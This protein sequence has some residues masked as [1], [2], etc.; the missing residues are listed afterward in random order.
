MGSYLL[1][2]VD[3]MPLSLKPKIKSYLLNIIL[4]KI[5]ILISYHICFVSFL[6]KRY[7]SFPPCCINLLIVINDPDVKIVRIFCKSLWFLKISCFNSS[8]FSYR[9]LIVMCYFSNSST[10]FSRMDWA[11][12]L[13][14]ISECIIYINEYY[15]MILY[16]LYS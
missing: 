14:L 15:N 8:L 11:F 10:I 16:K 13:I 1:R 12:E 9:V 4:T 7:F 6:F 2:I 3:N 5:L